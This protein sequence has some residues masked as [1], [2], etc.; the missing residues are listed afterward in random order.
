MKK[1]LVLA[2][3]LIMISG[4]STKK[5]WKWID[6]MEWERDDQTIRIMDFLPK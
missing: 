3:A 4:C 5:I 1:W 6:E 2:L